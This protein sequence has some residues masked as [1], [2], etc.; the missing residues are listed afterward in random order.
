MKFCFANDIAV[1]YSISG[2]DKCRHIVFINSL[3]TDLRIWDDVVTDLSKDYRCLCYDKRGHGLSGGEDE[4]YSI[5]LLTKD[6]FELLNAVSWKDD[7]ILVGLSVGGL[8]AQNFAY[9]HPE[10]VAGLVLMDTAAKIGDDKSWNERIAIIRERGIPAV[11]KNIMTRWLTHDFKQ[12]RPDAYA[13]YRNMLERTSSKAYCATCFAL[14]DSDLTSQTAELK[15]PTLVIV[16]ENDL[17][18]P[19][20]L[21]KQT[22]DLIANADYQTIAACGHLPCIEQPELTIKALR[23]FISEKLHG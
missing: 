5:D 14:R 21:V 18:T 9:H 15:L 22:A 6:L 16:G 10:K 23:S 3:G 2:A 19:P 20:Q 13:C 11:G 7:L 17:S 4:A 8:I 1:N 12:K